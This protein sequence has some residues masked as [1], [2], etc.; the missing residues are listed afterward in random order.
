MT[1][2]GDKLQ[3]RIWD[4]YIETKS[5]INPCYLLGC[6]AKCSIKTRCREEWDRIVEGMVGEYLEKEELKMGC[7]KGKKK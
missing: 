4:I 1:L 2:P 6:Y 3:N 7:K 5:I